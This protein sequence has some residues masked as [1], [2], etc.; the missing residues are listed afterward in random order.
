MTGCW[1]YRRPGLSG[2]AGGAILTGIVGTVMKVMNKQAGTCNV[3]RRN[4]TVTNSASGRVRING[5]F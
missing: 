5:Y 2:V 4:C 3:S 1:I